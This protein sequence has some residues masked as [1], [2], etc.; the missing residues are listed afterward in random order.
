MLNR[1][2]PILLPKEKQVS[3]NLRKKIEKSWD[4]VWLSQLFFVPLH[5][6][7]TT[8]MI[9]I[10]KISYND[11][12]DASTSIQVMVCSSIPC[13]KEVILNELNKDFE[14]KWKSLKEA[15]LALNKELEHCVWFEDDRELTWMDNGKGVDYHIARINI[16]DGVNVKYQTI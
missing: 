12:K 16:N 15:A 13:A 6:K 3:N 7:R 14:G 4:S 2:T 10:I 5:Y 9:Q 8:I 11:D 1:S